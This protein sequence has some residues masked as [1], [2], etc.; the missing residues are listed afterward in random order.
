MSSGK[1]IKGKKKPMKFRVKL[2]LFLFLFVMPLTVGAGVG[3][4]LALERSVPSIA[5][6]KQYRSIPSTKIYADDDTLI[7]ELKLQ[8]GVFMPLKKMPGELINAVVAVEDSHFW[9]HS[10][11][12]YFAIVRAALKDLIHRHLKEGGSTIT[13]QLAKITFLTPEKT[14]KRKLKEFVLAT[15]IEKNLSKAEILELYLNRVYFGHGA[16]GAEM[17]SRVYFGKSVRQLNLPESALLAGLLKAPSKY[18]PFRDIKKARERQK[19]VLWRMEE[20]EYISRQQRQEALDTS[21]YLSRARKG[22]EE[23]NNYFIEYVR[24]RLE[25]KYGADMLYKGGLRVYTTLNRHAQMEAQR[26][27]QEGLRRLDK[28]RGFRGPVSHRDKDAREKTEGGF[29]TVP[30]DTGDIVSGTVIKVKENEALVEASGIVGKLAIEDAAWAANVFDSKTRKTKKIKRFN[31]KKI[32]KPG[33]VIKVRVKSMEG[34]VQYALEQE[35]EVQGALVSIEPDSGYLRVLV[36]GYDYTKSEYNRAL[37]AKRQPGSAFKPI[38]YALALD[39]GFTPAS[40]IIDEEITYEDNPDKVWI[41]KNYDDEYHGPTRLRDAL[42]YSRNVVTV[43][44][45]DELG[46]GRVIKYANALGIKG[47]MPRD[48]TIAL[49]SLSITPFDLT[50]SYTVF[51]NGGMKMKPIA[52][53]YVTD[54]KGRVIGSNEPEGKRVIDP[55]TAFLMT[56]ML[57]DVVNYGTGWRV[58]AVGRPVAGKTGTTNEYRDAWFLGYTT[59]LVTGVWVGFDDVRPLGSEET[60]SRAAAPIWLDFMRVASGNTEPRD[61]R[62]PDGVVTRLIDPETGLLANE[63]TV[64]SVMEY[65]KAGT[66]PKEFSPSIWEVNEPD[67]VLF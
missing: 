2:K 23:S 51:A 28:R 45:V 29:R 9:R 35:T 16:Y 57:K 41:P 64:N 27:L 1:K 40:I 59:D 36:G 46:V 65:F 4:Y 37:Y 32:L 50:R 53:K 13:Q 66:E 47:K 48:L 58:R 60:G 18:S 39:N 55:G 11:I 22:T 62:M 38:V 12:D 56:S 14:F 5:E 3:G 34:G 44:I 31:L 26:A 6:L 8:K 67:D 15:K 49:G 30:P 54:R 33:D 24:K 42:A 43:K 61:F 63:W 7:G 52:V 19:I 20:E 25:K 10:G 17:A 21:V